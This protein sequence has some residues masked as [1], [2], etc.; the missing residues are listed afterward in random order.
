VAVAR[1]MLLKADISLDPAF[2]RHSK[3]VSKL[4]LTD[5]IDASITTF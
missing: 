5:S 2:V 1:P 3:S 4:L